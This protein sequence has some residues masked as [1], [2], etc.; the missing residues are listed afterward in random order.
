MLSDENSHSSSLELW[1]RLGV[2]AFGDSKSSSVLLSVEA[3][4]FPNL[5]SP[6]CRVKNYPFSTNKHFLSKGESFL[7]RCLHFRPLVTDL[8]TVKTVKKKQ[9]SQLRLFS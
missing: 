6:G 2:P 1:I 8:K 7:N 4:D 9:R 5:L 3:F